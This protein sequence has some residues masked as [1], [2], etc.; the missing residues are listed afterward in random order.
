MQISPLLFLCPRWRIA[1][2][3]SGICT[4]RGGARTGRGDGAAPPEKVESRRLN[5][6][7]AYDAVALERTGRGE[8]TQPVADHVLSHE[9]RD[10]DL[11]IVHAEGLADEIRDDHRTARPSL[12]RLLKAALVGALNLLHEMV[13]DERT[14][15]D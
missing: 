13:V 6:L 7:A 1:A 14:L 4:R 10:E 15:L 12:D 8:F 3:D 9:D 5:G 11:A 2:G